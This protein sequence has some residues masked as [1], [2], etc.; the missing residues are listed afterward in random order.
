MPKRKKSVALV[1][2][3]FDRTA[4]EVANLVGVE[5]QRLG[6]R[7]EP[8]K[9]GVKTQLVRSHVGFEVEFSD[10]YELCEMIPELLGRLGGVDHLCRVRDQVQP[11]FSEIHFE[12]PVRESEESQGGYLSTAVIADVLQ[13]RTSLS[14]GFF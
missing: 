11:E 14:F 1:F 10:D 13:L 5:T 3:G 4:Q 12:L 9:P 2:R 8:V 7:G 6:N